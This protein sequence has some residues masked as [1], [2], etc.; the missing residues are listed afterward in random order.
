ME[1]Q[2]VRYFLALSKTLNFTRAAEECNVSQPALTR[3]IRQL[4]DEFG[5]ALIRRERNH[6][7]L[8][9]L[10]RRMLPVLQQCYD[11]AVSAKT[12][13]KAVNDSDAA[14]MNVAVSNCVNMA[15]LARFFTEMIRAY[16]GVEL[17]IQR[18]TSSS[19]LD[20]LKN[21]EAD[22]AIAGPLEPWERLDGW[23]LFREPVELAV[24][25]DHRLGRHNALHVAVGELAGEVFLRRVECETRKELETH[26]SNF[27]SVARV[28]HEVETDHDL[29]ALIEANS[30]VGFL[31]ATAPQ[32]SRVRRLK[33]ADLDLWRTI[34]VYSVAG[35]MRSAT[36]ALFLSLLRAADWAPLGV[37]EPA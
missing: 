25:A 5:G 29:L 2:Q 4:E 12:L 9:E 7:H 18:G 16:P 13:A 19:V 17:R 36:A 30:G 31:S 8:T 37:S 28:E 20:A 23:P 22:I 15:V 10:G 35:R 27:G 11:A 14:P 24:N 32:S 3:S 1:M 21:G 6:S 26:F 34:S 33:L